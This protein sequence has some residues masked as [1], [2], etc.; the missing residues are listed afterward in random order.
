M[1]G[2]EYEPTSDDIDRVLEA[3]PDALGG[4]LAPTPDLRVHVAVPMDGA[5]LRRLEGRAE[6]EGRPFEDVVCDVIRTGLAAGQ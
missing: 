6:R 2:M 5:T 1:S 3:S 4:R